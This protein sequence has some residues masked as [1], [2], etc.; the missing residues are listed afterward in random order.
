MAVRLL[1][2]AHMQDISPHCCN[3]ISMPDSEQEE[4][5]SA[6]QEAMDS[7]QV[8]TV[9]GPE[10]PRPAHHPAVPS[11]KWVKQAKR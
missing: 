8:A 1:M 6:F 3:I 7:A 2:K 11:N 5:R 10:V 4:R 9:L